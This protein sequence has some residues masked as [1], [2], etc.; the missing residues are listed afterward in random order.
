MKHFLPVIFLLAA[1]VVQAAFMPLEQVAVVVDD[2]VILRS[3]VEKRIRDVQFQF[4]K[5]KA[6]L[7]AE[8]ILRKQVVEQLIMES[9]QLN[10]AE[11][12]RGL[13]WPHAHANGLQ[14]ETIA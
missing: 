2:S 12:A 9:L 3:D 8:D 14:T 13:M 1:S 4:A 6:A 11:R 7:P 5:R 10:L